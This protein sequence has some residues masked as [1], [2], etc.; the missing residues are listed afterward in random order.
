MPFRLLLLLTACLY[1]SAAA[2]QRPSFSAKANVREVPKNGYFDLVFTIANIQS[3]DF[4]PPNLEE[5]FISVGGASRNVS[6]TMING[7]VERTER[8]IYRLKPRRVGNFVIGAG[9]LKTGSKTLKTKPVSIKVVEKQD[10][11][12]AQEV[13][14]RAIP[15]TTTAYIGQQILIDYK[16]YTTVDIERFSVLEEPDYD[17]FYAEEVRRYDPQVRTELYDGKEYTTKI[18]R[19][20]AL[21]PQQLGQVTVPSFG[22]QLSIPL[23]GR[24]RHD[25]FFNRDV[26]TA[27]V[28]TDPVNIQVNALPKEAPDDFL[29][30]VGDFELTVNYSHN[31][32]T[33]DDALT[34][35]IAVEGTGDIKRVQAPK[36]SLPPSFEVYDP[37]TLQE[38]NYESNGEIIGKKVFEYLAVPTEVGSYTLQP[39]LIHYHPDSN[40]YVRLTADPFQ[41]EVKQ[42]STN[43]SRQPLQNDAL[44]VDI[45]PL[46]LDAGTHAI[47]PPFFG[48]ALFWTLLALPFFG[49]AG[50]VFLL[51]RRTKRLTI[52]PA[53]LR[54]QKAQRVAAQ[55]LATAGQHLK[56]KKSRAFY[57]E[58]S[59][60]FLGY[61]EDKLH[62]PRSTLT[63]EGLRQRLQDLQVAQPTIQ[64][65]MDILRTSEVAL[66]AGQ[67]NAADMTR[68]YEAALRVLTEVD[69][70]V[71]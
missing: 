11:G 57:D 22:M 63:K 64:S 29:G 51:H 60:A 7:R 34:V 70:S 55:R 41:L 67:D 47:R 45:M 42:G 43:G 52:D 24:R 30:A 39:A 14:I 38:L 68:I 26:R 66:F 35:Q 21:F 2:A 28:S 44:S 20:M 23:E 32:L 37:N 16:I 6:T 15:S 25:F 36:L 4:T 58:I 48:S 19:R 1:L 33:T 71:G 17:N 12:E 53:L 31:Q 46:K 3:G 10:Q 13:F 50:G 9:Q 62:I 5:D 56:E 54:Q 49:F 40:R 59:K 8:I 61:V 18:L 69:R 65:V 27:L